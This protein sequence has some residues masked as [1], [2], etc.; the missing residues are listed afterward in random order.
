MPARAAAA[1]TTSHSTFG[2]MS[3]PQM[4]PALVIARNRGPCAIAAPAV[5]ASTWSFTHA[6][7]GTV[8]TCHAGWSLG[9]ADHETDDSHRYRTPI[10]GPQFWTEA[11]ASLSTTDEVPYLRRAIEN[12]AAALLVAEADGML[13]GSILATFDADLGATLEDAESGPPV[14]LS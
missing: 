12:P 2:D 10:R 4:R 7:M 6:G 5:H 1:R 13:V 14:I 3:S 8:R 9:G 11:G